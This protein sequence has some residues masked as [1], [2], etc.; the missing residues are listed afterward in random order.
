MRSRA[1][2]HLLAI[3][4]IGALACSEASPPSAPAAPAKPS[5]AAEAMPSP[6]PAGE[7]L[8]A[9]GRQAYLSNCI[10]CHNPDPKLEGA[11]GPPVAGASLELIEAR[12][13]RAE[14]PAGYQPKRDTRTMVAMPFLE[15][16]LPALAAYLR[17]A[18]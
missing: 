4:A 16:Q 18:G 13:M 7:A 14:Y 6:E 3:A 10:A 17:E 12:V 9:Q 5:D 1:A 2:P 15:A 8:A 11:L